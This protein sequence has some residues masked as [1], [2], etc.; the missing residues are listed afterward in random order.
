[1]ANT[2]VWLLI[3]AYVLIGTLLVVVCIR[4]KLSAPYKVSLILLTTSFYFAVYLT[5][6][7]ILGWPVVRDALPNQFKLVSS[8]IYEPNN[9]QGNRGVIYV[10]A[11]DAQIAWSHTATPRSYALPYKKELHKKLAEAQNKIIKGIG[12][13]GE[14]TNLEKGGISTKVG[15]AQTRDESIAINFYDLPDPSIPEK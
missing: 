7:K 13:L 1:M 6:P 9:A 15:A 10:W 12:Q 14:V 8:V 3:L 4:S 5:M 2:A 11:I